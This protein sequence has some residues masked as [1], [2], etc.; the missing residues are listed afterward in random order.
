MRFIPVQILVIAETNWEDG[1]KGKL[2]LREGRIYIVRVIKVPE[3]NAG[4]G[5]EIFLIIEL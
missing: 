4:T 3:R 2:V 5:E 1:K